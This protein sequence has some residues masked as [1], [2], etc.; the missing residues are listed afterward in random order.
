MFNW[1]A[2]CETAFESL[3][4]KLLMAPYP[5]FTRDFVLETDAS[6]IGLG[7][8]LSQY[9]EDGKLHPVAS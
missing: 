8:V 4:S 2:E 5:N 6:K 3:K 7:A 1:N 9:Q